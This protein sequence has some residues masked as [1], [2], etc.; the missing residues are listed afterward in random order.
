MGQ[1]LV[2]VWDERR[3]R[4]IYGDPEKFYKKKRD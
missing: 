1:D 2:E 3:T 4:K